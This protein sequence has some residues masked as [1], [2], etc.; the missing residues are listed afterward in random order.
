[1]RR[2]TLPDLCCKV[3]GNLSNTVSERL[4]SRVLGFARRRKKKIRKGW[5]E[6]EDKQERYR[7]NVQDEQYN[8]EG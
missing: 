4:N 3:D 6:Q 2:F 1:M 8:N 7:P 5:L